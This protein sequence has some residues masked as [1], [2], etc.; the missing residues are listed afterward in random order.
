MQV[1]CKI[2][3]DHCCLSGYSLENALYSVNGI[4]QT[5]NIADIV[6]K[7]YTCLAF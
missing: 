3:H 5:L 4:C 2:S 7:K 1:L 6:V